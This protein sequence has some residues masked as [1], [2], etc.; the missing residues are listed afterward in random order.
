MTESRRRLFRPVYLTTEFG[1][2]FFSLMVFTASGL[3]MIQV[4]RLDALQLVL[5]GTALEI[6]AFTFE[7]PTG[8]VADT[9][10]RRLSIIVGTALM[11]VGFVV[12]GAA[13]LFLTI[14]VAQLLWGIGSTFISGAWEAWIADESG[15][16]DLGRVMLVGTQAE[17]AGALAGLLASIVL[18]AALGLAVPMIIG[19]VGY[20][21]MATGLVA[22][23]PEAHF[24]PVPRD[25]GAALAMWSTF[26]EGLAT[27]RLR[28][29]LFTIF[30]IT[31]IGGAASEA[32]D[33]LWQLHLVDDVGLPTAPALE[34]IVW[35][36][37]ISAAA[38]GLAIVAARIAQ[39]W[40]AT[41]THLQAART[42]LIVDAI[43]MLA[44]IGFGLVGGLAAAA[45]LYLV[46]RTARRLR[47]PIYSAWIN[48]SLTSAIRATVLSMDAQL[49]AL[50]QIIGGPIIG[51]F[52][53]AAG[54]GQGMVV[55]GLV[56][57]S[58]LLL[59]WRT[60]RLHGRD[61]IGPPPLA[62]GP[63]L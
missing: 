5:V 29:V 50:G 38:Y 61:M 33:R 13:P 3:F 47:N 58:S 52:A 24:T 60:I 12:W 15:E 8:V 59:Y 56:V 27:V 39:R 42:L 14:L 35:I 10:S 25:N 4:A 57:G 48:Q 22:F 6:A 49:D 17:S 23:M 41:E 32:F 40:V 18:G 11:G 26:R 37:L 9:V 46:A 62:A 16:P 30:A 45:T 44:I 54:T 7:V 28:P 43:L 63:G 21:V 36:G 34:P 31:F 53:V 55:V 51:A 19:G 2:S 1:W 20:L